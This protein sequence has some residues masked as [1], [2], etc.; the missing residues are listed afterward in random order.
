MNDRYIMIH[1]GELGTKGN[2]KKAFVA[3]LNKNIRHALKNFDVN[4]TYDHDHTFV[5]FSGEAEPIISRLKDVSGIQRISLVYKLPRDLEILKQKSLELIKEA[6]GKTFKVEA[7]RTDKTYPLSSPE[8]ERAIASIILK[9]TSF[10]VDVHN[11]DIKVFVQMRNDASYVYL[12][13]VSGAGGYPLGMNGKVLMLLSGGIDSP[14]ASYLLLRRGIKIECL[15]FASPP[16]TSTAVIDKLEDIIGKLSYYQEDI[17]LHIV[18]F[19]KLQEEIYN[20]VDE[21]YCIT[22]M[23][24]MMVRIASIYAKKTNC[25]AIATGESVGQVASQTLNSIQ[26]INSVTNF[27]ILRPLC[28]LDKLD[29]IKISKQ[30]GTYDISIRPHEDCCTIFAPKKPKTKPKEEECLYYEKRFDY[31]TFVNECVENIETIQFKSGEKVE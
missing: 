12:N 19:T 25:L 16:Y 26:V 31:E 11:P 21:P 3:Q 7:K 29:I 18:P 23:R 28:T 13:T 30:I 2:N 10:K 4:V 9:N 24:R 8:I 20:H 6:E 1:Y 22:I 27:P 15:H 17:K 5:D 14:V